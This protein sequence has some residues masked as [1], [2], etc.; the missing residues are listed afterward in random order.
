LKGKFVWSNW[1]VDELKAKREELEGTPNLTLGLVG[2]PWKKKSNGSP[3]RVWFQLW[4][5][6]LIINLFC[7]IEL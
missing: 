6:N 7:N 3:L 5:S 1:D 4:N 2:W